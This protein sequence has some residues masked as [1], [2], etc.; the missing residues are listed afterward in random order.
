MTCHMVAVGISIE[1]HVH[2]SKAG[3]EKME[4][5]LMSYGWLGKQFQSAFAVQPNLNAISVKKVIMA[6]ISVGADLLTCYCFVTLA[7]HVKLYRNS[8]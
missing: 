4:D 5:L 7:K 6:V 1:G 2:M 8:V 3:W